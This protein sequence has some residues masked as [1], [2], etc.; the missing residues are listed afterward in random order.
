M[1]LYFS[2]LLPSYTRILGEKLFGVSGLSV[3]LMERKEKITLIYIGALLEYFSIPYPIR[4]FDRLN[5]FALIVAIGSLI[6]TAQRMKYFSRI[7]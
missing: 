3:G 7:P 1:I 4:Y 6:T 2:M 5:L